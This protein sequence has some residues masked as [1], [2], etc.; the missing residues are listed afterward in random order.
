[1]AKCPYLCSA[2]G[3]GPYQQCNSEDIS[4]N[5]PM[6]QFPPILCTRCLPPCASANGSVPSASSSLPSISASPTCTSR[7]PAGSDTP[8]ISEPDVN[9]LVRSSCGFTPATIEDCPFLCFALG[10]LTAG[11]C[12]SQDFT[13]LVVD[14]ISLPIV[15]QQCLLPCEGATTALPSPTCTTLASDLLDPTPSADAD[16]VHFRLSCGVSA[17]T[18]NECPYLCSRSE[19]PYVKQC[20]NHDLTGQSFGVPGTLDCEQCLLPCG[21]NVTLD[22][23]SSLPGLAPTAAGLIAAFSPTASIT[24]LV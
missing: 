3:G 9:L 5:K 17:A 15:C 10:A 13:G 14:G 7:V 11:N 12:S 4:G 20:F 1:M 21:L 16:G 19:N 24:K 8:S 23:T 2:A 22:L 6:G 18:V